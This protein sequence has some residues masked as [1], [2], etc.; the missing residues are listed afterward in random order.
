MLPAPQFVNKNAFPNSIHYPAFGSGAYHLTNTFLP[1]TPAIK[2]NSEAFI[3]SPQKTNLISLPTVPPSVLSPF[4]QQVQQQQQLDGYTNNGSP[5][6]KRKPDHNKP[7]L[8]GYKVLT[9]EYSVHLVP[10]PVRNSNFQPILPTV[11]QP[12]QSLSEGPSIPPTMLI[13]DEEHKKAMDI[14]NKYNIPAISPLQDINRFNYNSKPF[15]P[16]LNSYP[17]AAPIAVY[18]T[19]SPHVFKQL[20][21]KPD[22]D[23]KHHK[24]QHPSY[25]GARYP[26]DPLAKPT[27]KPFLPT[28]DTSP[29]L[30]IT[31]S[32]FTI[33]DAIT[34]APHDRRRPGPSLH[35]VNP[36][37]DFRRPVAVYPT[38]TNQ[39]EDNLRKPQEEHFTEISTVNHGGSD[40]TLQPPPSA[41]ALPPQRPKN[42]TK[43]RRKR[44]RPTAESNQDKSN[45]QNSNTY[46]PP[47]RHRYNENAEEYTT[48]PSI[49]KNHREYPL[50]TV[51]QEPIVSQFPKETTLDDVS[52]ETTTAI[53]YHRP[54]VPQRNRPTND[55]EG[56]TKAQRTKD[57]QRRPNNRF[58]DN[59]IPRYR[60]PTTTLRSTFSNPLDDV[61][62]TTVSHIPRYK[63]QR[64]PITTQH[65]VAVTAS[66]VDEEDTVTDF[67]ITPADEVYSQTRAPSRTRPQST[68]TT[69]LSS[70][71]HR[72]IAT[73]THPQ[74][75]P[76]DNAVV[77]ST[78]IGV[79][80]DSKFTTEQEFISEE[81]EEE[82]HGANRPLNT[83][84]VTMPSSTTTAATNNESIEPSTSEKV[85]ES[86][87]TSSETPVY[88]PMDQLKQRH[89]MK[90][91]EKLM[92]AAEKHSTS[93]RVSFPT[94]SR[95]HPTTAS[96]TTDKNNAVHEDRLPLHKGTVKIVEVSPDRENAT[97]SNRLN[98]NSS[99]YDAKNRP[100][101][102]V[103][104]YRNRL[105]TTTADPSQ[106]HQS[107]EATTASY[108][109][110]RFPTRNRFYLQYSNKNKTQET[111]KPSGDDEQNLVV[112]NNEKIVNGGVS[113]EDTS[114]E[115]TDTV[116]RKRFQPKDRY[117]SKVKP[118]T[119]GALSGQASDTITVKPT[120]RRGSTRH[121]FS[122]R[123]RYSTTTPAS[124][125][126]DS[127]TSHIT[128]LTSPPRNGTSAASRRPVNNISLRQRIQTPKRKDTVSEETIN[129]LAIEATSEEHQQHVPVSSTEQYK[130]ETAIMKI[131][132]DDHSYRPH[133]HRTTPST[134]TSATTLVTSTATAVTS[135]FADHTDTDSDS[136]SDFSLLSSPSSPSTSS[137]SSI[138]A[139]VENDLSE[140]PSHQSERVAELTIFG[141]DQFNTV[142]KGSSS[143][144]VP[145]YFTIATE[146]PILPIEAFFPQVKRN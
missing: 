81:E 33:E 135:P 10:P 110:L 118:T 93:T 96:T 115:Q 16:T 98:L 76:E 52:I 67:K 32:F 112:E 41:P 12:T 57:A 99:K 69:P 7:T 15:L 146:D 60:Q 51:S 106:P 127:T 62:A 83:G 66:S 54:V 58:E 82:H 47:N 36:S 126:T 14:L 87:S 73:S 25:T 114:S 42:R 120:T 132:K 100:R 88:R 107:I 108:T 102:S 8:D 123:K 72:A 129:D 9:D 21:R 27:K 75:S 117:S 23:Y 59:K 143:R 111:A 19:Q 142:N 140:S 97:K 17:T 134:A 63:V 38:N 65:P 64:R 2:P 77:I 49:P 92:E 13:S 121:D 6:D 18:N 68:A 105:S 31:H 133:M 39:I 45:E 37:E 46:T 116:T 145:G 136:D 53:S 5:N 125:T 40:T 94:K 78:K 34:H 128:R 43:L 124:A 44:P 104:E 20:L 103:K 86:V 137:E 71:T 30:A 144:R 101:F 24:Q 61:E 95:H 4:F 138:D 35:R 48:R 74:A 131:A 55:V 11:Q 80:S 79:N 29:D 91:K 84:E 139:I 22:Y 3:L 50:S 85:K 70:T 56:S 113:T 89:R 28:P 109:K 26:H 141:S 1:G 90:Q 122:N 119:D 130:H